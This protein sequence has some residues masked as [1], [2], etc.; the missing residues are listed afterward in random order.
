MKLSIIS[1]VYKAEDIVDEL[2]HQIC[3]E[4]D[5]ITSNYEIIL[6]EDG[7]PDG[8][9]KKI[10]ENCLKN[11]KVKGIK[12]SRNF[13]QHHAITAGLQYCKGDWIVVMD[14]DLQDNPKEIK[15]LLAKAT[16]GYDIILAS[17][18][19][20]KDSFLKKYTSKLFYKIFSY[21]SGF[22]MDGT[23]ANFGI[24]NRKTVEAILLIKE[25]FRYFPSMVHWVGFKKAT[26]PVVHQERFKGDSAYNWQRL[27]DLATDITLSYSDK[28]L[29]MTVKLGF[30][31]SFLAILFALYTIYAK[32]SGIIYI[33]GY[34]SL[35]FSVWFLSGLIL[36]TLGILG[37]Y[38][39]KIFDGVKSRPLYIVD[40]YINF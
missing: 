17:R 8:C 34:S 36:A 40:S 20:R 15:N 37:L 7:S 5:E 3:T 31:I 32:L 26:I 23:V 39:S 27:I 30:L 11:P 19:Q 22:E 21:L 1:P 24:Y 18:F 16:E 9:W 25:P 29:R 4:L 38:I 14:C 28:P 12:L 13:G 2:V 6:V 10:E 33:V 35:I